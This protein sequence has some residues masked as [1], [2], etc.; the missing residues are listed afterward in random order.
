MVRARPTAEPSAGRTARWRT[1]S[2]DQGAADRPTPSSWFLA[3]AFAACGLA[4]G[5]CG[6]PALE[7]F[8]ARPDVPADTPHVVLDWQIATVF[9]PGTAQPGAP[10]PMVTFAPI[11]PPPR[12]RIA[13]LDDP[14]AVP[15]DPNG[16]LGT[17]AKVDYSSSDGAI[18]IP[19]D[20]LTH[21]W[22]L[23]YTLDDNIPH[24]V[25]WLPDDRQGHLTVPVFGRLQR[26]AVPDRAGYTI[27]PSNPPAAGYT[28]PRVFTTGL[29]TEGQVMPSPSGAAID[30]DFA[31]A[32]PL[33]GAIGRPDPARGDQALVVDY[34]FQPDMQKPFFG[35][36]FGVGSA[37]VAP[38][39]L[40]VGM[41]SPVTASWDSGQ[42]EVKSDPVDVTFITRLNE[43]LG[44]LGKFDR[45]ISFRVFGSA[46]ST[47][48]PG[49]AS[50]PGSAK[51]EGVQLPLPVMITLLVCPF[52]GL[53]PQTAQ[54]AMLDSFPR[55]LNVQLAST[56]PLLG[57]S[58][59]TSGMETVIAASAADA[60][61]V[62][63]KIAFPAAIPT[64][65]MLAT[66]ANGMVDLAG[67]SEQVA[68]G[69][70]SAAF[71][72]VFAP[73]VGPDLR[74]DY[75][76]VVLHRIVGSALTTERIYTVTAPKVR[77]DGALLV[78]GADY[79]FEIRSYKGHPRAPHGDFAPVDYPYGS[80]IVFTRTFK[81]S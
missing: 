40:Q 35:C 53:L 58:S 76:D 37:P 69:P 14:A 60:A 15:G 80:A 73:E 47:D 71:T 38:A 55:V 31:G 3:G 45:A 21:P 13:P 5:A 28:S 22:R 66:P 50:A 32:N 12:V 19:R 56:R 46:A 59:V 44:K 4:L 57:V 24:E 49:L 36:R 74:V 33:S 79:V 7:R 72:L 8:D 41:H 17:L 11:E 6:Y 78:P 34:V 25:Q 62:G 54:P 65:I 52:D 2:H 1:S 51:R 9:A 23:E 29:W 48:M 26:N 18:A 64:G 70:A 10:D 77:I 16:P 68:V 20:Y 43:G 39:T 81:A 27:T 61:G 67:D 42:K 75:Y 30:Y 63:F